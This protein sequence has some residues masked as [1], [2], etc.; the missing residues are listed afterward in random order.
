MTHDV[1]SH[2]TAAIFLASPVGPA[3]AQTASDAFP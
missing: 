1:R 2:V 3:F